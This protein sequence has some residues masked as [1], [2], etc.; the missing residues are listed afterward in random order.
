MDEKQGATSDDVPTGEVTSTTVREGDVVKMP[1]DV[2]ITMDAIPNEDKEDKSKDNTVGFWL[3]AYKV[4]C[5][6]N[7]PRHFGFAQLKKI[8]TG[9]QLEPK[10]VKAVNE[11]TYAFVTFSCQE[12]KEEALKVLNGHKWKGQVLKAKLAKP[13]EDPY[14]KNLPLK[15]SQ[16]E[17]DGNT[18]EAKRR[19]EEDS[20]PV[21]ERLNN[22]VT[23]LWNQPYENQ[24]STKQTNTREFLRNLSKMLQR[25]IGEISP[26]LKQ[27]R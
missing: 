17:S 20:L 4:V 1:T 19:K 18:Q 16:E 15:R 13:V 22:A 26:W 5:I 25:N 7:L 24:L 27:Q 23:P 14:T 6:Q 3:G 21:E 12:D 11:A 10:K 8:L 9:L 2:A